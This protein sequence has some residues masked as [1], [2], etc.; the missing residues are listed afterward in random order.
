MMELDLE[1]H[2]GATVRRQDLFLLEEEDY[3]DAYVL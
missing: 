1:R 2:V 3:M